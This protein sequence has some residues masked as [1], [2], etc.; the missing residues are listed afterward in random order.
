[1]TNVTAIRIAGREHWQALA[2]RGLVGGRTSCTCYRGSAT[3]TTFS[4][5]RVK[6]TIEDEK[7]LYLQSRV[8]T[9]DNK[10]LKKIGDV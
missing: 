6:T 1:V 4:D 7:A 8:Q 3:A 9:T 10:G 5:T 2:A